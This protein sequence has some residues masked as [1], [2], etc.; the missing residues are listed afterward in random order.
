[1]RRREGL[2]FAVVEVKDQVVFS[3]EVARMEAQKAGGLIDGVGGTFEFDVYTD[4][5]FV[6]IDEEILGPFV[7]GGEF[8]GRAEF[9]VAEPTA[10]A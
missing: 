9:F 2:A 6:V 1:M 5:G 4:G 10:E 3:D 7:F 8:V